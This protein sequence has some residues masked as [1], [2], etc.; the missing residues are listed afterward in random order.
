MNESSSD[1]TSKMDRRHM[2]TTLGMTMGAASVASTQASLEQPQSSEGRVFR[3]CLNTSTIRGQKLGIEQEIEIAGKA[4][5]DAM[6]PWF[7]GLNG[8]VE[9]GGALKDLRKRIEDHGMTIESAIGFAPWIVN[10]A[11]K[12]KAGLEQAKR[13]MDMLARGAVYDARDAF[14]EAEKA[15]GY[16]YFSPPQAGLHLRRSSSSSDLFHDEHES[17]E[18]EDSD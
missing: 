10:D 12:R 5:Y 11:A 2:L 13:E 7:D 3:Y 16:D 8:F 15:E 17:E 9:A 6:E 18:E 1:S 4:G 14:V